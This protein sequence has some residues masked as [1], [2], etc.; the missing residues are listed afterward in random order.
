MTRRYITWPGCHLM[1]HRCITY[2]SFYFYNVTCTP[3]DVTMATL[4]PSFPPSHRPIKFI[5]PS[6]NLTQFRQPANHRAWG[7]DPLYILPRLT[8]ILQAM[9][10]KVYVHKRGVNIFIL[11][12]ESCKPF[13]AFGYILFHMSIW[14]GIASLLTAEQSNNITNAGNEEVKSKG[15]KPRISTC[16]S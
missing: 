13:L 8:L 14:N 2:D 9:K 16:K 4:W 7:R 5:W 11:E 3:G 12:S 6:F 15:G 1:T 10:A